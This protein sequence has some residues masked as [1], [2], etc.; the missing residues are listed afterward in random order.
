MKPIIMSTEEYREYYNRTYK[1]TPSGAIS[2]E[3]D[4]TA[5][6]GDKG[7]EGA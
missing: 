1:R 4:G 6:N 7:A 2:P 3:Q 5:P